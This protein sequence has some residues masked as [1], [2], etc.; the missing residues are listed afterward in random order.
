MKQ[1]RCYCGRSLH[2]KKKLT[3]DFPPSHV[4]CDVYGSPYGYMNDIDGEWTYRTSSASS[5]IR[6]TNR[7]SSRSRNADY[8]ISVFQ[9]FSQSLAK[10]S[11]AGISNCFSTA[12]AFGKLI[13]LL[14]FVLCAGGFGYQASRFY[15]LYRTKPSVVQIEVENDGEV[16]FPAVTVCNTNR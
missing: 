11:I 2:S 13:W 15:A 1:R 16:D 4:M 5:F 6:Y 14:M 10:S 3:S 7:E 8:S 9:Y 12:N